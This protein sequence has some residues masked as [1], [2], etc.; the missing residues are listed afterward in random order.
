MDALD[1]R[2]AVILCAAIPLLAAIYFRS[3]KLDL[4]ATA[5]VELRTD[6]HELREETDVAWSTL[7][8]EQPLVIA[9]VGLPARGKS[10]LVKMIMRYLKWTGFECQVFNVGS[11][12]RKVGFASASSDFFDSANLNAQK[13]REDMAMVVQ[14]AMYTWLHETK[15][16]KRRVAIF[17]ATNTTS[18]RRVALAQRARKENVFLLFVESICDDEEVLQRNYELKIRNDDYKDIDPD[19]ARAD[20]MS[21]V[22]AY[23]KVYEVVLRICTSVDFVN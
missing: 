4:S 8:L 11:Y 20:F 2:W 14:D 18:S 3:K 21:R 19:T 1:K 17:D 12:R 16:S 10:Y 9:M 7:G 5:G 23:E 22:R 6:S 13:V 15:E